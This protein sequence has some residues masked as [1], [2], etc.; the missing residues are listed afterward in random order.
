MIS[1]KSEPINVTMFPDKTSQVWKLPKDTTK[2]LHAL[3]EW[4]FE[5]EGEFM[6]LAAQ[7]PFR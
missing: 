4:R 1:I 3:V 7:G 2:M 5:H 6:H